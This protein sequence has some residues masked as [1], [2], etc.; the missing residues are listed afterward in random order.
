MFAWVRRISLAVVVLGWCPLL[1]ATEP[2]LPPPL[3]PMYVPSYDGGP[4]SRMFHRMCDCVL[5]PGPDK[6]DRKADIRWIFGSPNLDFFG[7]IEQH[8]LLPPVPPESWAYPVP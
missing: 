4:V 5:P 8:R 7:V 1:G 6:D 3:A 2:D